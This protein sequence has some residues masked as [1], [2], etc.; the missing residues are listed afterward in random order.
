[1]ADLHRLENFQRPAV[2]TWAPFTCLNGAQIQ[3]LVNLNISIWIDAAEMVIIFVGAGGQ[4]A[5][6]F[7]CVIGDDA[8]FLI[9]R[10]P[11]PCA[12]AAKATGA[13][14]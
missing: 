2:A 10:G 13:R 14:T 9:Q 7:Q 12:N 11:K 5:A 6:A 8:E 3:P 1:V 4:V